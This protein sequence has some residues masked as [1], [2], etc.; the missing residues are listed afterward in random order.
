MSK[1]Q[2]FQAFRLRAQLAD[3]SH[4]VGLQRVIEIDVGSQVTPTT[5]WS[6]QE[7][8]LGARRNLLALP[9]GI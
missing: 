6:N 1:M 8:D 9:I 3:P 4:H 7:R 5:P 2:Q